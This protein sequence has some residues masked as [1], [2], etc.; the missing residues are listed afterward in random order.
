MNSRLQMFASSPL[1]F[2]SI[3]PTMSCSNAPRGSCSSTQ[4]SMLICATFTKYCF[5]RSASF[6][7]LS[8]RFA[9][10][11]QLVVVT[12]FANL[13]IQ[14]PRVAET[15]NFTSIMEGYYKTLF[16]LNPGSIQ[17]IIPSGSEHQ[18]FRRPHNRDSLSL[19]DKSAAAAALSVS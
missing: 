18:E 4:T 6:T 2:D 15:C 10:V 8:F 5:L 7:E 3:S 1:S 9:I 16:P 13:S 11:I 17:P 19:K 12:P 14:I